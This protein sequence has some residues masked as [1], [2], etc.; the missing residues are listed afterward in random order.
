MLT[1]CANKL[2]CL[3]AAPANLT[4]ND[5]NVCYFALN[6]EVRDAKSIKAEFGVYIKRSRSSSASAHTTLLRINKLERRGARIITK[7]VH[8]RP[9]TLDRE[10]TG[11]WY[12]F[13]MDRIVES[14]VQ[15]PGNNLG[16]QVEMYDFD[17]THL[18]IVQTNNPREEPHV[19]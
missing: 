16:L 12:R 11:R 10:S 9:L 2:H 4:I 7:T 5:S 17:G 15:H 19:S 8:Q 13:S 3:T 1:R 14:W 6:S 18:A